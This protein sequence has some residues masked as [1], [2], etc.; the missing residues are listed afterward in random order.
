MNQTHDLFW[1]I[2]HTYTILCEFV[3][4]FFLIVT[5][6]ETNKFY[7]R[8]IVTICIGFVSNN[9]LNDALNLL[10]LFL[11]YHIDKY[12]EQGLSII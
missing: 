3:T 11:N 10:V 7:D 9:H 5:Q 2:T 8:F 1:A 12:V 6:T 4:A